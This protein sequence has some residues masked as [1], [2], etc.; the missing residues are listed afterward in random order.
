MNSDEG[1]NII[2]Y[3]GGACRTYDQELIVEEPLAIR[4]EGEPYS[5]V[6]RTPGKEIFHV[7]GFCLAEGLV[8]H[9]HDFGTIG[10]C[11]E[12]DSNVAT[13]TLI[14][15]RRKKIADLLNRRGFVSQTSC[16]I[17]GKELIKDLYQIL[18]PIKDEM[19]ISVS[20]AWECIN[21]LPEHQEL[22]KT[23]RAAHGVLLFDS[24]LKIMSAAEDVGRH[25]A[26]DKAIGEAFMAGNIA[27]AKLAVLSSR[28]SY[29]L[30][31]KAARAELTFL[32]GMSRPTGLAVELGRSLNMTLICVKQKELLVFTG[33]ERLNGRCDEK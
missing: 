26:L 23:T 16:G 27:N 33:Q 8:E 30:V 24:K 4:I 7:A 15:E 14:P 20:Q 5:V 6:M 1:N 3:E 22:Y 32:I 11:S 18:A 9:P 31:Q 10:F 21:L 2:S 19:K 25:N 17:C 29:E 28:I 12:L 13:V